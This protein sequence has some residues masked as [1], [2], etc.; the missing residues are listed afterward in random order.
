MIMI[1]HVQNEQNMMKRM[2]EGRM[3]KKK[4]IKVSNGNNHNHKQ[5]LKKLL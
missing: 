3:K 5:H 2:K 4:K 1:L